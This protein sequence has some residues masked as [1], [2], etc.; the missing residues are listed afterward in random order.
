MEQAHVCRDFVVTEGLERDPEGILCYVILML[1]E[2]GECQSCAQSASLAFQFYLKHFFL[3]PHVGVEVFEALAKANA[4]AGRNVLASLWWNRIQEQEDI[5]DSIRR[6]RDYLLAKT[7]A[8]VSGFIHFMAYEN[9]RNMSE[10]GM[11]RFW[12]VVS[13]VSDIAE[14]A[15]YIGQDFAQPLYRE[16]LRMMGAVMC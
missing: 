8:E 10:E 14:G 3:T 7:S 6:S 9:S 1:E 2:G 13:D 15:Q 5:A 11:V 16:R 12:K 4:V